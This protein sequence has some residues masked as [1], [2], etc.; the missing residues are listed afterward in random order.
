M[1]SNAADSSAVCGV[2]AALEESKEEGVL[3]TKEEETEPI[4]SAPKTHGIKTHSKD[5]SSL[6]PIPVLQLFRLLSLPLFQSNSSRLELLAHLLQVLMNEGAKLQM[7]VSAVHPSH[8]S[9][10]PSLD[11]PITN[12]GIGNSTTDRTLLAAAN[13]TAATRDGVAPSSNSLEGV[14]E[15]KVAAT[16]PPQTTKSMIPAV[17][18]EYLR[19]LSQT[20][21]LESCSDQVSQRV[22]TV[23]KR[24]AVKER[25]KEV[26]IRCVAAIATKLGNQVFDKLSELHARLVLPATA[27]AVLSAKLTSSGRVRKRPN[28]SVDVESDAVR[29]RR[30]RRLTQPSYFAIAAEGAGATKEVHREQLQSESSV[31]TFYADSNQGNVDPLTMCQY[32]SPSTSEVKLL[33]AL[34]ILQNLRPGVSRTV[35]I[36]LCFQSATLRAALRVSDSNQSKGVT[37]GEIYWRAIAK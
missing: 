29:P 14:A 10:N 3:E 16:Q 6:R 26:L 25:N 27:P 4:I 12:P 15:T 24:L 5:C 18:E 34:Q 19:L 9:L 1:K 20:L 17:P 13:V 28:A 8:S 32:L 33:H 22:Q 31:E 21:L 37:F 2:K 23:I 35:D 36:D 11:D 30:R 7:S